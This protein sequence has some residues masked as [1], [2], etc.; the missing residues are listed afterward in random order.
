MKDGSSGCAINVSATARNP[1]LLKL[2]ENN[3]DNK[4]HVN[5]VNEIFL[6]FRKFNKSWSYFSNIYWIF[7]RSYAFA[8]GKFSNKQLSQLLKSLYST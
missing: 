3:V 4:L 2:V 5:L 6:S 1:S 8:K 7:W